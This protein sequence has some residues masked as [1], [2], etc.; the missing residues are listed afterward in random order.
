[1]RFVAGD[2]IAQYR[3][4]SGLGEGGMGQ[5]YRALDTRLGRPV[6]IKIS[7]EKF[8]KRFKHEVRAILSPSPT[9]SYT[10]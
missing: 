5:V 7:A 6:A 3:I 9:F 2:S 10:R 1:M 4:V 8:S